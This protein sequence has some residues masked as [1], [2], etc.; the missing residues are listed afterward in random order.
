MKC[1]MGPVLHG[2]LGRVRQA[3]SPGTCLDGL[4]SPEKTVHPSTAG[5]MGEGA[6]WGVVAER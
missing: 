6:V 5:V 3:C 4:R 1:G 2:C